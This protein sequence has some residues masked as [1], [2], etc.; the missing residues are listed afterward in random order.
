MGK[1]GKQEGQGGAAPSPSQEA[2]RETYL[3][4]EGI[5]EEYEEE[6]EGTRSQ[7]KKRRVVGAMWWDDGGGRRGSLLY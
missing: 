1:Q 6:L 2:L 7:N 4:E 5:A 3:C